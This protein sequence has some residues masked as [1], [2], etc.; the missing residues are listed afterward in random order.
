MTFKKLGSSMKMPCP[1]LG[2]SRAAS[3]SQ[4]AKSVREEVGVP[5]IG[6]MPRGRRGCLCVIPRGTDGPCNRGT[7]GLCNSGLRVSGLGVGGEGGV[8][9]VE[10]S[11]GSLRLLRWPTPQGHQGRSPAE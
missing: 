2:S 7:E 10:T 4:K 11:S 6:V 8:A 3:S 9:S 1:D 5:G